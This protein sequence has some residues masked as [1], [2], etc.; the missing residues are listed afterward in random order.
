MY[1]F[2]HNQLRLA[3]IAVQTPL[4]SHGATC[5][6]S[7]RTQ[8]GAFIA[9]IVFTFGGYLTAYPSQQLA[10]L[11][12]DAWL[13]LILLCLSR[14]FEVSPRPAMPAKSAWQR[15]KFARLREP[16]LAGVCFGLA[17]LAGH[18]QSAFYLL[19]V[20]LAFALY[21]GRLQHRWR[22]RDIG[23]ACLC[24]LSVA[25]GVAAA[26][27][28]PS[29]EFMQVSS[30]SNLGYTDYARGFELQDPLQVLLP[31]S[32]S[33]YSPLYLGIAPLGLVI[34]A[35]YLPRRVPRAVRF[36]LALALVGL[37][38]S[39]GGN[40]FLYPLLYLFVP[41]FQLFRQ[42]ERAAFVVAFALAMLSGYGALALT[43]SL[44]YD[45]HRR[46]RALLRLCVAAALGAALLFVLI[47]FAWM[48]FELNPQSPF[49]AAT[50]QAA[51]LALMLTLF[52]AVLGLR[53]RTRLRRSAVLVLLIALSV[54]DLFTVNWHNNF[55]ASPPDA[56]TRAPEYL[57]PVVADNS[58]FRTYNEFRLFG[59]FG[60]LFGL[61]DTGGA[62][63]LRL[64][65]HAA[66]VGAAQR[67]VCDQLASVARRPR[68]A[69][70]TGRPAAGL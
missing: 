7:P 46:L 56:Q 64:A 21:S 18:P 3:N 58:L 23:L 5:G 16:A 33:L 65:A 53:V 31:G 28:L 10:I 36:W 61:E 43:Q 44:A 2:A 30:R 17:L 55:Q 63:P 66:A 48:Q 47:Y 34:A 67:Q 26:Q 49:R 20:S 40:L 15:E 50:S 32:V 6:L 1:L 12:T 42:Q 45:A 59:N 24:F 62:S 37:M 13:P 11:E 19:L 27:W 8:L 68:R 35:L 60:D 9:A 70:R 14:A 39:F 51:W 69:E 22:W 4:P 29:L 52:A 25:L 41:G 57:R 54:L 38:L